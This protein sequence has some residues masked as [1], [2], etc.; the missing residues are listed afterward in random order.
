MTAPRPIAADRVSVVFRST[1]SDGAVSLAKH[2]AR[3]EGLRIRTIASVRR[4]EDIPAWE[5]GPAW[6]VTL[7][8]AR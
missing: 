2:W 6:E 5:I 4:R 8:V 7:V 1:D 3:G